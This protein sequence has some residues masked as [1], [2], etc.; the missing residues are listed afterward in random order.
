MIGRKKGT[1]RNSTVSSVC[2]IHSFFLSQSLLILQTLHLL[3]GT[4]SYPQFNI[5]LLCSDY[6]MG[7]H[8]IILKSGVLSWWMVWSELCALP[9]C[10]QRSCQPGSEMKG[11]AHSTVW[12]VMS[13][14]WHYICCR[15]EDSPQ[16][17]LEARDLFSVNMRAGGVQRKLRSENYQHVSRGPKR[18]IQ[19]H[20][21]PSVMKGQVLPSQVGSSVIQF[22]S[23]KEILCF[24]TWE[25]YTFG[26]IVHVL[27]CF[28]DTFFKQISNFSIQI[29]N[30]FYFEPAKKLFKT[31]RYYILK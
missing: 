13:E 11:A 27:F 25:N 10:I 20:K 4:V 28:L 2:P 6:C 12:R 19:C 16:S 24:S 7:I 22:G 23:S 3:S 30:Q 5:F 9:V 18:V 29:S 15:S 21:C 14:Q 26:E 17:W 8:I 1:N 31:D